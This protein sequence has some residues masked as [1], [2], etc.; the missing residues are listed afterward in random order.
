M[1]IAFINP[2]GN[3]D[4]LDSYWTEHPDFGGQ[5]VYVKELALAMAQLGHRSDIITRQIIDPKWPRFEASQ[6]TYP[7]YDRVRI[8]RIP[9]GGKK[10][11]PKEE[12]WPHIG[13]E[14]VRGIIDF[15]RREPAFPDAVTAHYGDGGIT[16]ALLRKKRG[17]P[18][19]FT[20]HS[21]GAQK[22]DK[23][24]ATP[25]NIDSLDERF[26][27][28]S[29]IFAE[30]ISMN[31]SSMN[32][33]STGMEWFEQYGHPA[34]AGA[35]DTE[36]YSRFQVIPPGVNLSIFGHDVKC[37]CEDK[38]SRHIEE[39]LQRD[40]NPERLSLPL[41]ICSSRLDGKKNHIGL[42]KA[43]AE[44]QKL[45]QL[46]NL[47][48]IVR[49]MKN[50]L[51]D[52]TGVNPEE[53]A[54]L[55]EIV[56]IIHRENLW[57]RVT[58]FSLS[59]QEELASAYRYLAKRQSVF[60]LTS[61]YEP[62][63]LAQ[64]EAMAAGLPGVATKNGGPSESMFDAA[65]NK[66]FGV[67]VDPGDPGDISRGILR[68]LESRESWEK[69]HNAGI[70][71]VYKKYN[72][73]ITAQGYLK[74]IEEIV[75]MDTDTRNLLSIPDFFIHPSHENKITLDQ[76]KEVYFKSDREKEAIG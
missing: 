42:V 25:E 18:F 37:P 26:H 3:F 61:H 20:S 23:L 10:F 46:A 16:G 57:G 40:L 67:L 12:L 65:Q 72:W 63:G 19:T 64:L 13:S 2:Q 66:E 47:A 17:I 49:G 32:V 52:Q 50:P 4:P 14:F 51:K 28:T 56:K 68:V 27:F 45:N 22:M 55:E 8:I 35:V 1:H 75:K 24:K 70:Q 69:F 74:V 44:N 34:Y 48:I 39:M 31:Y 11:L 53:K 60:A 62:F 6:D 15:Y 71:R 36:D 21:L 29:R 30:R 33:V 7:G 9:F 58:S 41:I 5:L 43:F 38:V 54:I 73:K 76:L 59:G